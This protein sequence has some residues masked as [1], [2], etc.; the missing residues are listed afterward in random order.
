MYAEVKYVPY[1]KHV[2]SSN[3]TSHTKAFYCFIKY[4]K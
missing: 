3:F 4:F 2:L 1:P